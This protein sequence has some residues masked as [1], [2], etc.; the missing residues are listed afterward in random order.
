MIL[1]IEAVVAFFLNIYQDN[2]YLFTRILE[3]LLFIVAAIL[4]LVIYGF[5]DRDTM[6][7]RRMTGA[8]LQDVTNLFVLR[9]LSSPDVLSGTADAW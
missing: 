3:N 7:R 8:I 9:I 5:S 6:S 1:I 4:C 2:F